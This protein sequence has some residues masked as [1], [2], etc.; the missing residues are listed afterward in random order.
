MP[1]KDPEKRKK[2]TKICHWKKRGLK[3][4]Y[5]VIYEKWINST[6]CELCKQSYTDT[7]N[8]CMDHCHISGEFRN[9]CCNFCNTNMLD[10]AIQSNNIV[11]IKNIDK[12]RNGWR[13]QKKYKKQPFYYTNK[14]KNLVLWVKFYDYIML[15]NPLE[16][17]CDID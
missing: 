7:N 17:C 13:Y 12:Y 8:K 9:I 5:D 4:D 10:N 15:N 16:L 6:Y 2:V 14:N 3:G 1:Y 11:G